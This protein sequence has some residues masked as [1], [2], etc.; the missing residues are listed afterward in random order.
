M[1]PGKSVRDP[2][3]CTDGAVARPTITSRRPV[4]GT[5]H[6][7]HPPNPARLPG[8]H[9]PA[10]RGPADRA[11]G[12]GEPAGPGPGRPDQ[13]GHAPPRT[14][15]RRRPATREARPTPTPSPSTSA[16]PCRRNRWRQFEKTCLESD[17]HLA[18]VAACH[19]ILTLVLSEQVRVPPTARKRMYQLVKGRES[20]PDRK[21]GKTIPVGGVLEDQ[22]PPAAD[23]T[24][25]PFLL[26]M[27]AYSRSDSWAADRRAGS[28][29]WRCSC[30]RWGSPCGWPSPP[31]CN[32]GRRGPAA[33][34]MPCCPTD[35]A[36][37]RPDPAGRR[38]RT[39]A[40]G[41][42]REPK[43]PEK[44]EPKP[45]ETHHAGRG[46]PAAASC[47]ASRWRLRRRSWPRRKSPPRPDRVQ[48][49][50]LEK[51]TAVV[52]RTSGRRVGPRPARG[53]DGHLL[54]PARRAAGI[55][56][57]A[58]TR[59]PTC[60]S[61][62]GATCAEL[63]ESRVLESSV[64]PHLPA[65]G[66]HADLTVHAGRI[67][68]T[69]KRPAGARVRLRFRDQ[70]WDLTLADDKTEVVLELVH[71]ARPRSAGGAAEDD[72]RAGGTLGGGHPAAV[73][74]QGAGQAAQEW[75][76]VLGQQGGPAGRC[77]PTRG[78]TFASC[79][80]RTC[81]GS[82]R[83]STR[84]RRRWPWTRW[85]TSPASWRTAERVRATF[86][87]ALQDRPDAGPDREGRGRPP[88]S[89]CW[90]SRH[91]A[92]CR[93]SPT[94]FPTPTGRCCG[95]PRSRGCGP[96]WPATPRWPGRSARRSWTSSRSRTA[97]PTRCCGCCAGSPT[98]SGPTRPPWTGWW[99]GFPRRP[100]PS[101]NCRSS[102]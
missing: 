61:S 98:R 94:G 69:T 75:R 59:T 7:P 35:P 36:V 68:L 5:D 71:T 56:V 43:T 101:G 74:V 38:G 52:V 12:G 41:R 20:M 1:P 31:P 58:E 26:G 100:S 64:T 28:P 39:E 70:V 102:T 83:T 47:P 60:R 76:R 44:T 32:P 48:I 22:R 8:R 40:A 88:G 49:G 55:Q 62:C 42:R 86:D 2:D 97:R 93:A 16:T 77:G 18:E 11:E 78:R 95:K 82:S 92:T 45:P 87:E 63:F 21:P 34:A 79:R 66:F 27:S 3:S 14:L 53:P 6:A 67:Y 24:D 19:Q 51:P 4:P 33:A 15:A 57:A 85:P 25:A 46:S 54:G 30:W 89:R 13:T 65:D 23:D 90:C 37:P 73:P 99:P 81:R 10:R 9:P 96:R 91:W 50:R 80:R 29:R 72:R 84:P 17:V